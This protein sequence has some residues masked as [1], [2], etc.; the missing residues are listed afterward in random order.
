MNIRKAQLADYDPLGR[1]MYDAIHQG[2]SPYTQAQRQAWLPEVPQGPGWQDKLAQQ[3]VMLAEMGAEPQG[4]M[5]LNGAEID[6][7]F[8]RAQARGQGLFRALFAPLEAEA[9]A[10]GHKELTCYA[11]LMAQPAFQALGFEIV[12]HEEVARHGQ[13][14][15]RAYMTRPLGAG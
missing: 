4:F 1:V 5:T 14:L 11:S 9:R 6:L 8:I 3:V 2:G 13:T 10:A 12:H 7:A 15:S